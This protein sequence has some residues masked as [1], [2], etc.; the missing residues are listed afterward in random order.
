MSAGT[1][2]AMSALDDGFVG[3]DLTVLGRAATM[4]RGG[5]LAALAAVLLVLL[6][7][8]TRAQKPKPLLVFAAAS[9]Q[10]ALRTVAAGWEAETGRK[11]AIS[12]AAS[13]TLARQIEQGAP[14]DLFASADLDWMDWAEQR[15]LIRPETR[16]TLL[17][18]ALVLVT[19]AD[20]VIDLK[21]GPGFAL[22]AAIGDTRLATGNPISVP[23]G[24][25]AQAALETLGVWNQIRERIA[26]A[27]NAAA[28]LLLVAR[29]EA[30]LGIVYRTDARVERRVKVVGEFP[31]S[32][33]PPIVYPFART[34]ASTHADAA[35][36]LAYLSLPAA[37]KV[38]EAEGF[39]VL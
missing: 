7:L 21:I 2:T 4:A 31:T 19:Q 10:T 39:V 28:A 25:Y 13:S 38:F 36:F 32:S 37:V 1:P 24:R 15:Q 33:H 5:G 9:L 27:D 30:K 22:A 18:N 26:G 6:A 29:G 34:A 20:T 16:R 3:G 17:G 14:A 23:L 11:V 12:Y 35:A 8:P